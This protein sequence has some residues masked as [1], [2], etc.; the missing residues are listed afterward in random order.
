M[1]GCGKVVK[2][3]DLFK[4]SRR[5][6][7]SWYAIELF[8]PFDSRRSPVVRRKVRLTERLFQAILAMLCSQ[9]RW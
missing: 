9:R 1:E 3:S 5:N 2:V 4:K 6:L 8:L 7:V